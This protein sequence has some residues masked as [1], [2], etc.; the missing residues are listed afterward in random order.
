M[1]IWKKIFK[2]YLLVCIIIGY[3]MVYVV[4]SIFSYLSADFSTKVGLVCGVSFFQQNPA[5][6]VT[7]YR[8]DT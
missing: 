1:D 5:E 7:Q 6:N 2:W 3:A 4:M 8:K